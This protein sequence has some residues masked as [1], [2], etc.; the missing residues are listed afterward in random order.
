MIV[1]QHTKEVRAC[2]IPYGTLTWCVKLGY[3]IRAQNSSPDEDFTIFVNVCE[4]T[5]NKVT[6]SATFQV[7]PN[8][9]ID[10]YDN[11]TP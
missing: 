8:A 10:L 5:I 3:C 2:D 9:T 4:G 11:F 1:K 7:F 6:R